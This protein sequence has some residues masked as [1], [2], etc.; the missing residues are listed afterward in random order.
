MKFFSIK[1]RMDDLKWSLST[2]D[3]ILN[4]AKLVGAVV[5]NT[6]IGVSKVASEAAPRVKERMEEEKKKR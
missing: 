5:A 4:S 1:E 3:K 6:A 2:G